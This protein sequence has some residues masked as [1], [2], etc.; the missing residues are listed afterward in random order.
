[1][2]VKQYKRLV[3]ISSMGLGVISLIF[4]LLLVAA[5]QLTPQLAHYDAQ[6]ATELSKMV[7]RPVTVD[8]VTAEWEGLGPVVYLHKVKIWDDSHAGVMLQA[9]VIEAK[10]SI[11]DFLLKQQVVPKKLI[12]DHLHLTLVQKADHSYAVLGFMDSATTPSTL[13][14][15]QILEKILELKLIEIKNT[16]IDIQLAN[17]NQMFIRDFNA[18]LVHHFYQARLQASATLYDAET[19]QGNLTVLLTFNPKTLATRRWNADLKLIALN[20]DL[21]KWTQL[22]PTQKIEVQSGVGDIKID[23]AWEDNVLSEITSSF[24]LQQLAVQYQ[25]DALNAEPIQIELNRLAADGAGKWQPSGWLVSSNLDIKPII[26][27]GLQVNGNLL[28]PVDIAQTQIDLYIK[29]HNLPAVPTLKTYFPAGLLPEKLHSWL[30]EAIR[31]GNVNGVNAV[32]RGPLMKIPFANQEGIFDIIVDYSDVDLYFHDKWPPLQQISGQ[33]IFHGNEFAGVINQGKMGGGNITEAAV[34]IP[35]IDKPDLMLNI[36]GKVQ[37]SVENTIAFLQESPMWSRLSG[38]LSALELKGPLELN[39]DLN[40]PLQNPIEQTQVFGILNLMQT[41]VSIP[42]IGLNFFDV[43]GEVAFDAKGVYADN[44]S[45]TFYDN[46]VSV[47]FASQAGNDQSPGFLSA[48]MQGNMNMHELQKQY[49]NPL[50]ENWEGDFA[51]SANLEWREPSD[52]KA[53]RLQI[54]SNLQGVMIDL[55]EPFNKEA[56]QKQAFS[57]QAEFGKNQQYHHIKYGKMLNAE[58]YFNE[59]DNHNHLTSGLIQLHP[60]ST[61]MA[62]PQQGLQIAGTLPILD[63]DKWAALVQKATSDSAAAAVALPVVTAKLKL[64]HLKVLGK[65]LNVNTI[66]AERLSQQWRV[67]LSGKD[68]QGQVLI[69]HNLQQQPIDIALNYLNWTSTNSK[70]PKKDN[71]PPDNLPNF[72]VTVK[73]LTFNNI[74]RGALKLATQM[75][76]QRMTINP[77][78]IDHPD[79]IL[80]ATGRWNWANKPSNTAI[81]GL[82]TADNL[83]SML[84]IWGLT[85]GMQGGK[86]TTKLDI[87][88]AGGPDAFD[89]D[90]LKGDVIVD[91]KNGRLVKVN[92]G[93]GRILSLFSLSSL[94]RRLRLDFSDVFKQGFTFDRVTSKMLLQSGIINTKNGEVRS[95]SGTIKFH[96]DAYTVPETFDLYVEVTPSLPTTPIAAGVA[97]VNPIIGAATWA[98]GKAV[99][100]VTKNLMNMYYHVTGPW[101]EPII[102]EAKK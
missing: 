82:I 95:T 39:L 41:S 76:P 26:G 14:N 73:R 78:R 34:V 64:N 32:V 49:P 102:T 45:A 98:A 69:P 22:W 9:D 3:F 61:P 60:D 68:L 29:G 101:A 55:P 66:N 13:D 57:Y 63:I 24:L 16:N 47:Q 83:G 12:F 92:P 85:D 99:S 86:G 65:D 72:N 5:Y 100:P 50:W 11:V 71:S 36:T 53:S 23:L 97:V 52:P 94:T 18:I 74:D 87:N 19:S 25:D 96:G 21:P 84:N 1:M 88:W 4:G 67:N 28:I 93:V 20:I 90:T 8:S 7:Q 80:I 27:G 70:E 79:Y 42:A 59:Q 48:A 91:W 10:I 62:V 30:H 15:F 81:A 35:H 40:I 89:I 33:L 46:P 6:I 2:N 54:E 38:Q 17:G 56:S 75:G 77:L 51:Y 31:A 44:L 37:S 58:L 43:E